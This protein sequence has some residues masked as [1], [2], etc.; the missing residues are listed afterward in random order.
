MTLPMSDDSFLAIIVPAYKARFLSEALASIAA[1]TNQRFRL[2]VCDDGSPE[3]LES[4]FRAA[5]LPAN[6]VFHRFE[7]NVGRR[8]LVESWRRAVAL[9]REPWVWMFSD[10]DVMEPG[11]VAAFYRALQQDGDTCNVYRF[12][13]LIINGRSEVTQINPPHPERES[14]DEFIYHRLT[15]QRLSYAPE[16]IF[17]RST[18]ESR[19]GFVDFPYALGSDDASW[20]N[21]AGRDTL[22]HGIT[23]P[24]VCWRLSEINISSFS[25]DFVQR[26]SGYLEY[27]GWLYQRAADDSTWKIEGHTTTFRPRDLIRR[28]FLRQLRQCRHLFSWQEVGALADAASLR[29]GISVW[30]TRLVLIRSNIYRLL[31]LALNSL[32]DQ[33]TKPLRF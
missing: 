25:S 6:A 28:W 7:Q 20:I 12:N 13:T 27:A 29:L 26:L 31:F 4:I 1:Q 5:N 30:H 32:P 15:G 10:D 8:S 2:Y 21:I 11:C 18:Y 16:H 33:F 22:L 19:G 9:G 23:G 3:N 14:A 17:R 24:R